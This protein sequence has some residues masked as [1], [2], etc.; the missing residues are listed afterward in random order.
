MRSQPCKIV[1]GTSFDGAGCPLEEDRELALQLVDGLADSSRAVDLLRVVVAFIVAEAGD[2]GIRH[3]RG[4]EAH[5][6]DRLLSPEHGDDLLRDRIVK[7]RQQGLV[8]LG[9]LHRMNRARLVSEGPATSHGERTVVR[10]APVDGSVD[11]LLVGQRGHERPDEPGHVLV[12]V[13]IDVL[14]QLVADGDLSVAGDPR[15]DDAVW[16]A[17]ALGCEDRV[18][19]SHA[20]VGVGRQRDEGRSLVQLAALGRAVRRG[21]LECVLG[22]L[23]LR[24]VVVEDLEPAAILDDPEGVEAL[25]GRVDVVDRVVGLAVLAHSEEL[26]HA[27][28]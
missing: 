21:R 20:H 27:L 14:A 17:A 16:Q 10:V 23:D 15:R 11:R 24:V 18:V 5:R 6:P 2:D 19:R 9:R 4:G 3:L 8:E 1:A 13:F 22:P 25:V 12:P 7:Q 28:Q 26:L